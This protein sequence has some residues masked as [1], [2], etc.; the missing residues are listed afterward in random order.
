M[1]PK[2]FKLNDLA[3][4]I[5]IH[6]KSG[7]CVVFTNG[8]FDIMHAGHVRYLASARREGDILVVGLNSDESV[9]SIKEEGRPI[10]PQ[11]QRAE[12]LAGLWCVD[13]ITV[14]NEP[15]P[16]KTIQSLKPDVLVKG[17][18]WP[19]DKIIGADVVK[20][21]GGRVVRVPV[22]PDIS[23]SKIIQRILHMYR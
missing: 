7:R 3:Q 5:E 9:K 18:D 14:F 2:I 23:T 12:V 17:D 19:E 6:R 16:L 8:C 21:R 1:A 15:D 10:V 11:E 13:F 20:E 4:T 22:V